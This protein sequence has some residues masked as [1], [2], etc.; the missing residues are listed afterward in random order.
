M[1]VDAVRGLAVVGMVFAHAGY[2][3]EWGEELSAFVGI[4]HGHS[5][6]LF[7]V[8]AGLSL[9]MITGGTN[10]PSGAQ[11]LQTRLRIGG[12][13]AA[14]LLVSGALTILPSGVAV[15]LASYALWFVL[16]LPCL[17]WPPKWLLVAG[18]LHLALGRL[19]ADLLLAM[20]SLA[21]MYPAGSPE[22]FVPTLLLSGT[23]PAAVWLGFVLL[24]MAV[25]R[26]G[27]RETRVLV[28]FAAAGLAAFV[29]ASAPFV[30][31]QGSLAPIFAGTDSF[32]E[33]EGDEGPVLQDWCL[34][35]DAEELYPCTMAEYE[36]Q[37]AS[38][39]EEDYDLY[40]VLYEQLP[41]DEQTEL[42]LEVDRELLY[43]CT[44][45]EYDEQQPLLSPEQLELQTR[46]QVGVLG[47]LFTDYASFSLFTLDPHSGSPFEAFASGGLAVFLVAGAILVGRNRIAR[48][49]MWPLSVI[50]SMTLTA[51]AA[52]VVVI[53]YVPDDAT[54]NTYAICLTLG[55]VLFCAIWR[56]LFVAGPLE[57]FVGAMAD[58]TAT[59]PGPRG[60]G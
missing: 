55:L 16:V 15:I 58:R 56:A 36:E 9:G 38:F 13:A 24:G 12:R 29:L 51:Y 20:L 59:I 47:G 5:S 23:Y 34:D 3:G 7:A 46:L 40:W 8:V 28:R 19:V 17:R 2:V 45:E 44:P 60:R 33:Q 35:Q 1:G 43:W 4:S 30:I 54:S 10:P 32:A 26:C 22:D 42:C 14:L 48:A 37:E 52:H 25:A 41:Y 31:S 49:A 6:I 57:Y 21:G 18:L 11:L 50:G 27:I 53:A 39:T